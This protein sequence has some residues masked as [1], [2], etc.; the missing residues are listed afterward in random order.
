MG[1]T[2]SQPWPHNAYRKERRISLEWLPDLIRNTIADPELALTL[3][4]GAPLFSVGS[5]CEF[6]PGCNSIGIFP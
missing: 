2:R 1:R 5:A 4:L 3:S 6:A